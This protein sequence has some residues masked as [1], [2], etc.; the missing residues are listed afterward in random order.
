MLH[1][2][3]ILAFWLAFLIF[4]SVVVMAIGSTLA[5]PQPQPEGTLTKPCETNAECLRTGQ[6]LLAPRRRTL[7]NRQA[8]A[9]NPSVL[10]NIITGAIQ[11]VDANNQLLGYLSGAPNQYGIYDLTTTYTQTLAIS[12]TPSAAGGALYTISPN[13]RVAGYPYLGAQY[14]GAVATANM[15]GK[16]GFAYGSYASMIGSSAEVSGKAQKIGT[17]FSRNGAAVETD[18]FYYDATNRQ[19]TAQWVNTDTTLTPTM[20]YAAQAGYGI[21]MIS[22]DNFAGF[23]TGFPMANARKVVGVAFALITL[24]GGSFSESMSMLMPCR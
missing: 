9:P 13:N 5:D 4:G 20:F 14:N 11:I 19:I 18:I 10:P 17:T 8:P 3:S 21:G 12:F 6:P 2:R 1:S 15:P 16:G 7:K 22:P 23:Q 24:T